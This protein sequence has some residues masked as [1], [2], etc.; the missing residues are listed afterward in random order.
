MAYTTI[1]DPSA[2]FKVQLYSGTGSIQSITFDDTDTTMQ[3]DFVWV[4]DRESTESNTLFD[5][6][7]GA[8]KGI[9]A[10]AGGTE[11]TSVNSL[12][13]FGS[14]G[15]TVGTGGEVNTSSDDFVAWCWK[16]S[17]TAGF[18]LVGWTGNDTART[19]SH[20]LSAVPHMMIVK[21]RTSDY[22]WNIYHHRNT[23]A[24]ETDHLVWNTNAAT[25]DSNTRW[26]DT[27][28]TSS[29]FTLGTAGSTN[30]DTHNFI[31]YIF[32]SIQG[33]SKFGSHTWG[34]GNADNAFVYTG[35]RPALVIL[36]RSDGS[37]HW[38]IHDNKRLGYNG[39]SRVAYI[40]TTAAEADSQQ[41]D[42][43]ANGFKIRT[44]DAGYNASGGTYVYMAFADAPFVNSNGV[45]ATAF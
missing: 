20:S 30:K 38:W 25:V 15:F 18:D 3:P 19:I 27:A 12:T 31:G 28:P 41:I 9:D 10:D 5:S 32:T 22:S 16:E 39:E 1:D 13:A 8:T 35:F 43:L 26:N 11:W 40:N 17:A 45:P 24:P 4:K 23:S 33:Y 29:V 6:V 36:K 42:L 44:N 37:D 14:D 21:N 7:R 34:T 2:Y